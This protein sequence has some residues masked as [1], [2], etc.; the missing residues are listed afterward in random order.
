MD[1]ASIWGG[2]YVTSTNKNTTHGLTP[3][4]FDLDHELT[5]EAVRFE[6]WLSF[7]QH[8]THTLLLV[9]NRPVTRKTLLYCTSGT[10]IPDGIAFGWMFEVLTADLDLT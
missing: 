7:D 1:K 6:N 5:P 9:R 8:K 4:S 10:S 3:I 2:P